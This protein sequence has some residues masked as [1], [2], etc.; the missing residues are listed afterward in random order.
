MIKIFRREAPWIAVSI[1]AST[2]ILVLAIIATRHNP[3]AVFGLL[4]DKLVLKPYGLGQ[5]L[6]KTTT[7]IFTG[8]GC[9][10]AF[11]CG[12]FNI[13]AEGQL[14]C[15]AFLMAVTGLH[16]NLP[17]WL[18][19]PCCVML[20]AAG[21]GLWALLPGYLKAKR[22]AHEVITT[23]MMNFIALALTNYLISA[24]FHQPETIHTAE[25]AAT[26]FLPA[27]PM[28]GSAV[29]ASLFIAI[30]AA[31]AVHYFLWSTPLGFELRAVGANPIAAKTSGIRVER[32]ILLILV[33]SGCLS[34]LAGINFIL[35]YKHYFEQGFAS[36][37]GFLGIAVA[38]VAKNYPIGVIFSA[39]LFAFLSQA[40]LTVQ[41]IIPRELFEILQGI[42][43]LVV[44]ISQN[45]FGRRD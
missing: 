44:V 26:A 1:L 6:Y 16:L 15:G 2:T 30:A 32:R 22:G 40:G 25:L 3:L 35:G 4:I 5:M 29:N 34:G 11:R 14:Y 23:M 20:A 31:L 9:A 43:I 27:L 41:S 33:L 38:L 28:Q 42:V 10:L 8:L 17:S 7:L 36:G 19:L 18:M 37:A 39:I 24:Y 45:V 12:L 21:G 13:G